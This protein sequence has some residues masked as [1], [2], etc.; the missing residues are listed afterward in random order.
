MTNE[1]IDMKTEDG[2]QAEYRSGGNN[3]LPDDIPE[4]VWNTYIQAFLEYQPPQQCR[5]IKGLSVVSRAR[6]GRRT[7]RFWL[8]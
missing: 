5:L 8:T 2:G 7:T 4:K 3:G 1:T 6:K